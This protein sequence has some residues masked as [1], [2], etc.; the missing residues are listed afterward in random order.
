[1]RKVKQI[2]AVILCVCILSES[3][4]C[5]SVIAEENQENNQNLMTEE[6]K[7]ATKSNADSVTSES[8]S[9]QENEEEEEQEQEFEQDLID[10]RFIITA[11]VSDATQ[12][13]MIIT[14][15]RW[16][17]EE[18]VIY[19]NVL[20]LPG[21]ALDNPVSV[22][23]II[24]LLP[25]KILSVIE[26]ESG[27]AEV[28]IPIDEWECDD[29]LDTEYEGTYLFTAD[30]PVEY[31]ILDTAE[32]LEISVVLGGAA[33]Q[34]MQED[35]LEI[36][37]GKAELDL[38]Y[39]YKIV[40]GGTS[41]I[42]AEQD[43]YIETLVAAGNLTIDAGSE[44][45][46]IDEI[47]W[48]GGTITIIGNV[49][50]KNGLE[51][52]EGL[53]H[54]LIAD[55]SSKLQIGGYTNLESLVCKGG[56]KIEMNHADIKQL[57]IT[58]SANI[59]GGSDGIS[60]SNVYWGTGIVNIGGVVN[61]DCDVNVAVGGSGKIVLKEQ[62]KV[63]INGNLD[64]SAHAQ[65]SDITMD[66]EQNSELTVHG[67]VTGYKLDGGWRGSW[68]PYFRLNGKVTIG[69]NFET[70]SQQVFMEKESAYV[71]VYGN[72][73]QDTE[74]SWTGLWGL[75][76]PFSAGTLEVKG[77][78]LFNSGGTDTF[79]SG[80]HTVIFS[81]DQKQSVYGIF[82]NVEVKN[83]SDEGVNF[84]TI[85]FHAIS[86]TTVYDSRIY[87]TLSVEEDSVING[88]TTEKMLYNKVVLL[89]ITAAPYQT[90]Y[91]PNENISGKGMELQVTYENGERKPTYGGWT[92][93]T[94]SDESYEKIPIEVEFGGK[95]TPFVVISK[96]E[97]AVIEGSLITFNSH[98]YRLFAE[99]LPWE[100]V[101]KRCKELG[102][103]PVTITSSEENEMVTDLINKY[104]GIP[105]MKDID[106]VWL[107]LID[108]NEN[109]S[110]RWV[111]DEEFVYHKWD[112]DKYTGGRSKG[113]AVIEPSGQWT[114]TYEGLVYPFICEWNGEEQTS[115]NQG[116]VY[117]LECFYPQCVRVDYPSKGIFSGSDKKLPG[118]PA[119]ESEIRQYKNEL[120]SWAKEFGYE[121][122]FTEQ[123]LDLLIEGE[124]SHAIYGVYPTEDGMYQKENGNPS[125]IEYMRDI[126]FLSTL[127][128]ST[129]NWEKDYVD[130]YDPNS[131]TSGEF[132]SQYVIVLGK[133]REVRDRAFTIISKYMDYIKETGRDPFNNIM[134]TS[135]SAVE[136][137][138]EL[139]AFNRLQSFTT[140]A[141]SDISK[142][143]ELYEV[144]DESGIPIPV[145]VSS[146][147]KYLGQGKKYL[148][149]GKHLI[150]IYR[151]CTEKEPSM[152]D[153]LEFIIISVK[154]IHIPKEM[155]LFGLV[156]RLQVS[157]AETLQMSADASVAG[158]FFMH[159]YL[160]QDDEYIKKYIH[161]SGTGSSSLD[162]ISMLMDTE[163]R[164]LPRRKTMQNTVEQIVNG[165]GVNGMPDDLGPDDTQQIFYCVSII[166]AGENFDSRAVREQF[167]RHLA[168]IIEKQRDESD[169]SC[170]LEKRYC[171]EIKCPVD[172]YIYQNSILVGCIVDGIIE[173]ESQGILRMEVYGENRD[174]KRIEFL[175]FDNFDLKLNATGDGAMDL[176]IRQYDMAGKHQKTAGFEKISLTP[177]KEMYLS[178]ELEEQFPEYLEMKITESEEHIT[179]TL[180]L[181]GEEVEEKPD[182]IE[183]LDQSI[184][185]EAGEE[186]TIPRIV[187]PVYADSK[188][189]EWKSSNSECLAVDDFGNI[190]AKKP[191]TAEITA[192]VDGTKLASVQV[193]IINRLE[194]MEVICEDN[195]LKVGEN[196]MLSIQVFPE[197]A[198]FEYE[199]ASENPE[200]ASVDEDGNVTARA[201]GTARIR[202][203]SQEYCRFA[204]V[205]IIV[206]SKGETSS[207]TEQEQQRPGNT[208]KPGNSSTSC[209]DET[210]TFRMPYLY[211][212]TWEESGDK[213]RFLMDNGIYARMSWIYYNQKWYAVGSDGFMLTGWHLIE[214]NWYYFYKD[215]SMA[216]NWLL[217]EGRYYYFNPISD[218][219][220]GKML[221]GWQRIDGNWYYF[222]EV[223]DGYKGAMLTNMWIGTY[224]IGADGIWKEDAINR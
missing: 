3:I 213:W 194:R 42:K 97:G 43:V 152:A 81:G 15:W 144:L 191:G 101:V 171:I 169:G 126:I 106:A 221:T 223:S 186:Y 110:W 94:K 129:I 19:E 34:N 113:N 128:N 215:G 138:E 104:S 35:V 78:Y 118:I 18:D 85:T 75:D 155:D 217:Y 142:A 162:I 219:T 208:S 48:Q 11:T 59:V 203:Y 46:I 147:N 115:G 146:V 16:I 62:A 88:S 105:N 139:A 54:Q 64:V 52:S 211:S 45:I 156:S 77:D 24:E 84:K 30:I 90:T 127:H 10:D 44:K 114:D 12:Q 181:T 157:I 91:L 17:D 176:L 187:I 80:T 61:F 158:P 116:V 92:I 121:D 86:G 177:G 210:Q 67:N 151:E 131:Y 4:S 102:G 149:Y 7:E 37:Q 87:G 41:T 143:Q 103:Y 40:C 21:T 39:Y 55:N 125:V 170:D 145:T 120:Y 135:F 122:V 31:E 174:K 1:M 8:D 6:V 154:C 124:L 60:I 165:A 14:D 214:G 180:F 205:D 183:L 199:W 188:S 168:Q 50:L 175:D 197:D 123:Y 9:E 93:K 133:M 209:N 192:S 136:S 57:Q 141:M 207:D 167:V 164:N 38:P 65:Q 95:T 72:Y 89:E 166:N 206:S 153:F 163:W 173:D 36:V 130:A 29:F 204:Y 182:F 2:L 132:T 222:N 66:C 68:Y 184:V 26:K 25:K 79:L 20:Y 33:E 98:K 195:Q 179:P 49:T 172:V 196:K 119:D 27:M 198:V 202:A 82:K 189:I 159:M 107:G 47:Y 137:L 73:T 22:E 70:N 5:I 224:F 100:D 51:L 32:K 28:I 74:S 76:C 160:S 56:S 200:I 69:G 220:K 117:D 111:S 134:N 71:I 99:Y 53:T 161:V 178:L 150:N 108:E 201:E 96:E 58:G 185:M 193:D 218:G 216:V 140:N 23:D 109:G 112:G 190:I 83:T 13:Q 212:G 63:I 148:S